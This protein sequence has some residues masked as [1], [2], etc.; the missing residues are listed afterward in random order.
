MVCNTITA[1]YCTINT[2]IGYIDLA[3]VW[4]NWTGVGIA[5]PTESMLCCC[6]CAVPL[7]FLQILGQQQWK[8]GGYWVVTLQLCGE[9]FIKM[10][11]SRCLCVGSSVGASGL[12]TYNIYIYIYIYIYTRTAPDETRLKIKV[13]HGT[14]LSSLTSLFFTVHSMFFDQRGHQLPFIG[15]AAAI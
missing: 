10:L 13:L 12:S 4:S 2:A 14:K 9:L 1:L 7:R 3:G 8:H 15:P 5:R 11:R 6:A